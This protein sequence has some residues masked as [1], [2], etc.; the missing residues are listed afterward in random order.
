MFNLDNE[1]RIKA[2]EIVK[3]YG[4]D[5]DENELSFMSKSIKFFSDETISVHIVLIDAMFYNLNEF[6]CLAEIVEMVNEK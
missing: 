4:L 6:R 2:L 5:K 1:K 3:N